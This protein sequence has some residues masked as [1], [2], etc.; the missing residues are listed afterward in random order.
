MNKRI[1]SVAIPI[2]L[3]IIAFFVAAQVAPLKQRL[4]PEIPVPHS[5]LL[6]MC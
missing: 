5:L 3:E 6:E 4:Y 1:V 2:V